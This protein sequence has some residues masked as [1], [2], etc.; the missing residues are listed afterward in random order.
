MRQPLK[1]RAL[2]KELR[3]FQADICLLQETHAT[4]NDQKIW[5]SEWGGKI[6]FS[7][8]TSNSRGVAFL[9][10]RNLD[11]QITQIYKDNDGR[12]MIIQ[13]DLEDES[14]T[15]ANI[16]AP[17]QSEARQ[18][19]T[20]ITDCEK[21]LA[22]L[23]IQSLYLGGDFNTQLRSPTEDTERL[24]VT[25]GSIYRT[26]I[27]SIMSDYSLTDIWAIKNPK[28]K[29]GTF[30]RGTY[31]T[32]IDY[33]LIPEH[34]Q[35]PSTTMNIFPQALSDHSLLLLEISP[36]PAKPGPG[37]W[38]FNNDLLA[39]PTFKEKMLNHINLWKE[40]E[41]SNPNARWEWLKYKIRLFSIEYNAAKK[42]EHRKMEKELKDRL[43]QLD[44]QQDLQG[45]PDAAE[46]IASIKR[47]L[48]E[49]ALIDDDYHL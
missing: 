3:N 33:W 35:T 13:M 20:F 25:N 6:L 17:T 4:Q 19:V 32:R 30:R 47:E 29:K 14:I 12:F 1:R 49:I 11:I 39:D 2:F 16:Y 10:N 46:E 24:S 28:S 40:D 42:R 21:V 37:H 27:K 9:L 45:D 34:L 7:N 15:I 44:N 23:N 36:S 22:G 26:Q 18:Q 8:G 43:S 31:T 5:T 41:L 38:K 48:K